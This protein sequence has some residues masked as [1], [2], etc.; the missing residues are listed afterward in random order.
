MAVMSPAGASL[1]ANMQPAF[2][3]GVKDPSWLNRIEREIKANLNPFGDSQSTAFDTATAIQDANNQ[4][5][6]EAAKVDREFQQASAREAM[7][8][9]ASQAQINREFQQASAREAMEFEASEAQKQRDYQTE[10]SNTAYQRAVADL[11][12]AGLNPAL[13]YQQGG[14]AATAGAM[15]SGVSSSGSMASG[16]QASGSKA[17]TDMRSVVDMLETVATNAKDERV[18]MYGIIGR[19]LSAGIGALS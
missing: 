8:F 2:T 10:M 9:E 3:E 7:E 15:A 12:A 11:K 6:A 14:A 17:S 16:K 13:A 1:V 4:I 5:A 18:A 19:I